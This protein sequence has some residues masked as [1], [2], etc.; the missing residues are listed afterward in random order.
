MDSLDLKA[1]LA[2]FMAMFYKE[3]SAKPVV[4]TPGIDRLIRHLY[5]HNIPMAIATNGSTKILYSSCGHLMPFIDKYM[6]H[7]VC[8]EDDPD[9]R[10]N[11]PAPD[12]YHVCAKRFASPPESPHNCVVF[13]D[14]LT[15]ITGAVASGM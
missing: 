9:V 5:Q 11:K 3:F 2:E 14:S 6:T 10:H 4:L 12:I 1:P 13:E 7:Y 15:G 8:G